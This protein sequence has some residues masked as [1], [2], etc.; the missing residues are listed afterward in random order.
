MVFPMWLLF[1]APLYVALNNFVMTT[2]YTYLM[3][4]ST[5]NHTASA[6][7]SESINI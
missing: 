4:G 3:Y 5:V 7:N 1:T 2:A 6:R